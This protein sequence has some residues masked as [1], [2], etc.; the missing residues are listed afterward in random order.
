MRSGGSATPS[1]PTRTAIT[2]ICSRRS[3]AS[4]MDMAQIVAARL[5]EIDGVAAVVL[6][7]SR[8]RAAA[9][10]D[11]DIDL[12]IYYHPD[13]PPA[14]A[15]LQALAQE[16]DDRHLPDLATGYGE[17]GPWINGGGWLDIGGARVDWLYRD[18]ARVEHEIAEC[19]AGR[20]RCY[21]QAGHPHG[22]YN[23][24]Y[25]GEVFYCQPLYERDDMLR[26]LKA[27]TTPYPPLLK[28]A[29]IAALWEADFSLENARKPASRG[30]T[31]QVVG[32][33]YRTVAVMVQALFALNERY[34]INEK[35]AAAQV[36]AFPLHPDGFYE[37]VTS[38]LSAAGSSA[39]DLARNVSRMAGIV[40]DARALCEV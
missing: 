30:D 24:I 18:L 31:V 3:S 9:S 28:Q 12:G 37:R 21:Y 26:R 6:G 22:F 29:L 23:H 17:W 4:S 1:S 10:P 11:S 14:L 36:E 20:V 34:C 16:L 13:Q 7:G 39:D 5:G 33:L 2:S 25:M 15:A 8:A 38:V 19:E 40:A 35:G 32:Y 27:R